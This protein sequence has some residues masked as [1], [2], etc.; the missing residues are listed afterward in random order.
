M[1]QREN[2]NI[3]NKIFDKM[4][5]DRD[6]TN[7]SDNFESEFFSK[8]HK[9]RNDKSIT[10][11]R[12]GYAFAAVVILIGIFYFANSP[13]PIINNPKV[14][15]IQDSAIQRSDTLVADG[16]NNKEKQNV[17]PKDSEDLLADNYD[18]INFENNPI[19]SGYYGNMRGDIICKIYSPILGSTIEYDRK[20][21]KI[22]FEG[23]LEG[24]TNKNLHLNI[25]IYLGSNQ[26]ALINHNLSIDKQGEFSFNEDL[27]LPGQY[28]WKIITDD[29]MIFAGNFFL[30]KLPAN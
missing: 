4:K 16:N 1:T 17:P 27:E 13:S 8:L 26:K 15:G 10:Y 3:E 21:L 11:A 20:Q 22:N 18:P 9:S 28:S 19:L 24:I 23:K 25:K 12:I 29:E 14:I 6:A 5:Q 2:V 7:L 30:G